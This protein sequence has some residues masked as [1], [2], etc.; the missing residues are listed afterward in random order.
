MYA[1]ARGYLR[2]HESI[3]T[4]VTRWAARAPQRLLTVMLLSGVA[5]VVG[6]MVIDFERWILAMPMLTLATIGGWGILDGRRQ[7]RPSLATTLLAGILTF[8]GIASA[9]VAA[10]GLMLWIMGP[11][12]I[13]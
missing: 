13:L 10:L 11:A 2:T 4:G 12:P 6:V 9:V 8:V 1:Q 7:H 5:G 3:Y